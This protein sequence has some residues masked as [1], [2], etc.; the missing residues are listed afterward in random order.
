[1][2]IILFFIAQSKVSNQ[3]QDV[4]PLVSAYETKMFVQDCQLKYVCLLVFST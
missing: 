2:T 3:F 1:M 4:K